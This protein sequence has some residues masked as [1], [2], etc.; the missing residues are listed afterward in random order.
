MADERPA[1]FR[2]YEFTDTKAADV[3]CG[4]VGGT[5]NAVNLTNGV[6]STGIGFLVKFVDEL[7][8]QLSGDLSDGDIEF[9]LSK[10]LVLT[11]NNTGTPATCTIAWNG[12]TIERLLGFDGNITLTAGT[13]SQEADYRMGYCW[14]PEFCQ[15]DQGVWFTRQEARAAGITSQEGLFAGTVADPRIFYREYTFPHEPAANIYR[16]EATDFYVRDRCLETFSEESRISEPSDDS[17]PTTRGFFCVFSVDSVEGTIDNTTTNPLD[18]YGEGGMTWK[19]TS[20]SRDIY[21]FCSLPP[22]G[23][24]SPVGSPSIPTGTTR[25]NVVVPMNTAKSACPL[26]DYADYTP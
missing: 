20:A 7:N 14:L 19:Y 12:G 13:T 1:F 21:I 9:A 25:Y 26:T 22:D 17:Y 10:D 6:Y 2:P 4:G 16:S 18:I 5:T 8:A 15:A 24:P 3:T 11:C 23:I